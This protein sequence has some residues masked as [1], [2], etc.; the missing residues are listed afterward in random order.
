MRM[1]SGESDAFMRDEEDMAVEKNEGDSKDK[2]IQ[3][4]EESSSPWKGLLAPR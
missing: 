1:I 4:E 2:E 3:E